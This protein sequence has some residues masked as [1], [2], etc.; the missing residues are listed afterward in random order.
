MFRTNPPQI[1]NTFIANLI[2]QIGKI[3]HNPEGQPQREEIARK[4]GRWSGRITLLANVLNFTEIL[5]AR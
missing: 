2:K 3:C 1:Y 5:R 4:W